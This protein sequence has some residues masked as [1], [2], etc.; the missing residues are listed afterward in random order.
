MLQACQ[1]SAADREQEKERQRASDAEQ[2][3]EGKVSREDLRVRNAFLSPLQIL[4]SSI[5]CQE[6][7]A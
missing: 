6:V 1:Y 3:R 5:S 2:L 4:E 7:F